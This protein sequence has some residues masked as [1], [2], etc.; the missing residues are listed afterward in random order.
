MKIR[1]FM[2]MAAAFAAVSC[3]TTTKVAES[4]RKVVTPTSAQAD[5]IMAALTSPA[6]AYKTYVLGENEDSKIYGFIPSKDSAQVKVVSLVPVKGEW[7]L[8]SLVSYPDGDENGFEFQKFEEDTIG[9]VEMA[10]VRYLTYSAIRQRDKQIQK[11]VN[12][13]RPDQDNFQQLYF[14]GK[15][16]ADGKIEGSSN[17]TLAQGLEKPEMRWAVAKLHSD[18]ELVFIS[19]A[20]IMT[21]QAI[22]WWI[23]KN[24]NALTGTSRVTF[25]K[26][27]P[28]SSLV[29]SYQKAKK[30][31]LDSYR[32]A[33]FN[34][35]GYTVVVSCKKSDGS[36]SLVWVE[37]I[38]KNKNTDR[39]LNTI[40]QASGNTLSMFY[41][42]GKTTFK[43]NLSL[44]NGSLQKR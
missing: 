23:S 3:G 38:C 14:T 20:D 17:E 15:R 25:G 21:D 36:Y 34:I 13:F 28:A 7:T 42:K 19:E 12:I 22:E 29:A 8:N 6:G 30:E 27:D 32:A 35:R 26:I 10:G 37:P 2:F 43:N 16:L 24:P 1:H 40:Y 5:S 31:N 9:V 39:Y 11:S 33:Y 44:A 4:V 41:Y 18:T